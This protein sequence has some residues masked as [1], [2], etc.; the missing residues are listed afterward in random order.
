M[1]RR[2]SVDKAVSLVEL[3]D[4]EYNDIISEELR[5]EIHR[6]RNIEPDDSDGSLSDESD[7]SSADNNSCTVQYV[8]DDS[9]SDEDDLLTSAS[10][11]IPH[12]AS[13]RSR[14]G[15]EWKNAVQTAGR[16]PSQNV[17][18]AR[19][20]PTSYCRNIELPVDAFRCIID[21]G[22]RRMIAKYSVEYARKT[23]DTDFQLEEY[24]FDA[25]IGLLYLRGALN[26]NN[27]P[28]REMWNVDIGCPK[29]K[30]T[31][32]RNRFMEIKKYIRF[33][34]R[35]TRS[36]RLKTDKFGLFSEVLSRFVE[37]SQKAYVPESSLTVDEQLLPTKARCPFTQFMPRKPDKFGIKFWMLAEVENKYC[38]SIHPYVGRD[39]TR[40]TGL[41]H[42]VVMKLLTPYYGKGYNVTVDNFFTS[43]SLAEELLAKHTSLVG[44]VRANRRELPSV[45]KMDLHDSIILQSKN[46]NLSIYQAKV[47]KKVYVLSTL[48]SSP[49]CQDGGK[50][51]P[52][53]IL[54]YNKNKCGVDMVDSMCRQMT[55]KSGSRRWPYAAFC[56]VLDCAA[57]NAW[58]IYRK[59][60][61]SS[62]PR[63]TFLIQLANELTKESI[64]RRNSDATSQ[65]QSPAA[66][67]SSNAQQVRGNCKINRFCIRNRTTVICAQ[68]KFPM[69]GKCT[70]DLCA[71]CYRP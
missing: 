7:Q 11:S 15:R 48:H 27:F 54:Y 35:N 20:G 22:L 42:H 57:L 44:T 52:E 30:A 6:L 8:S 10:T 40:I 36:E 26:Q 1:K 55:T 56:N 47:L 17:F 16:L 5:R 59:V 51:K 34:N 63:R 38:L 13:Y 49:T 3:S 31:M 62:I 2:F 70:A 58:I 4:D 67:S 61:N 46:M 18:R 69:C 14:D 24:E 50:R 32:S 21:P 60:C 68:C 33:D 64:S 53:S 29:F 39:H 45:Q 19:P 41:G 25:F 66:L 43:C 65:H 71:K 28:A 37:N 9:S 12:T 23:G